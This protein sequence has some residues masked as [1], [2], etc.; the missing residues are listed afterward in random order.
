MAFAKVPILGVEQVRV[1]TWTG[2]DNSAT[3]GYTCETMYF[4]ALTTA[5]VGDELQN[6]LLGGR[7]QKTFLLEKLSIGLEI[8]AQR[9]RHYLLA[10]AHPQHARVHLTD[11][12]L[13][14]GPDVASSFLLM[15]RK[16]VRGGEVVGVQC[17]PFERILSLEL[18]H[19]AG[20]TT[21]IVE[22]MGR[23]ANI[24][25]VDEGGRVLDAV[26][27]VRPQ[28]SRRF[29]MP[30][31]PY[32][33]PPPRP[34]FCP[35]DL[36]E[37]S[38]RALLAKAAET[39]VKTPAWRALVR[40]VQGVSPL[41]AREV[42]YRATG[43]TQ[44]RAAHVSRIAPLLDA[45]QDLFT[46][47][48]EGCWQPCLA[49]EGRECVAFAPY[50]L[51]QYVDCRPMTGI[52]KA[53]AAY[54]ENLLGADA[55]AAARR[56]AAET[57]KKVRKRVDRKRTALAR[58]LEAANRAGE[59]RLKG[60]M[61]L[62]YAH[63]V[64]PGQ[65]ELLAPVDLDSPPLQIALNPKL[66][67]VENAQRYFREYEKAKGAIREI[68]A[69]LAQTDQELYYLDQLA[70]DLSLATSRPEIVEAKQAL[71]QAGYL[72]RQGNKPRVQM[73]RS[74]PLVKDSPD[75][76]RILVGRNSRQNEEVTFKRAAPDD[77]WLHA[78]GIPG[79]HVIVK[80]AGRPVTEKTLRQAAALAAFYSRDRDE[81][82]VTVDY[83]ERRH[84][85]R[86]KGRHPGLVTYRGERTIRIKPGEI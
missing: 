19:P 81:P 77:L 28:L 69:R 30:G 40:G 5:A 65:T 41:L 85:R 15:L 71:I 68:P 60:E 48:G 53:V 76:F 70:T 6:M 59:L 24:I 37:L 42:V 74:Q 29:V 23:H 64:K 56:S 1:C 35:T 72:R 61:I 79:G 47:F 43:D 45:F 25:L 31:Q 51:Q 11:Q 57:I 86:A 80:C 58:S 14:R 44:T 82:L 8:Y 73:P 33:P 84:V 21:L 50:P 54:F 36:T 55:Y 39:D 7:V 52:S 22:A 27:R 10:S 32:T 13:R 49:Y 78:R 38:L 67:A 3:I 83:V 4:D 9:Q 16:Y 62:S 18:S 63:T 46:F 66:T 17:P 12:R 20:S 2:L 34:G 75:G 26:K